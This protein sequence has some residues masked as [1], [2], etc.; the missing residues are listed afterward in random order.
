M[1]I[2]LY[3]IKFPLMPT[4]VA[5]VIGS[6]IKIT[7]RIS[8]AFLHNIVGSTITEKAA[9]AD[10]YMH[11]A[12]NTYLY[13]KIIFSNAQG[14]IPLHKNASIYALKVCQLNYQDFRE[15]NWSFVNSFHKVVK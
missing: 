2:Y 3:V 9:Y 8:A 10:T 11:L 4:S 5:P 1:E 15:A 14:C 6:V 12:R 7:I 13:V